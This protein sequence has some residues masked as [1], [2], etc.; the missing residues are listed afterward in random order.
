M[1]KKQTQREKPKDLG[2]MGSVAAGDRPSLWHAPGASFYPGARDTFEGDFGSLI[3]E[4]IAPGH[5]PAEPLLGEDDLVVTLG[6]CFARELRTFLLEAGL[7]S[8]R[9]RIPD[10]LNNTYA[11]LDF[12]TWCATGA[13]TGFGFSYDR[14]ASGEIAEFTPDAERESYAKAFADAGAFVFTLGLAEVWSDKATGGVFWRGIPEDVFEE[15]RHEFRLTTV[16]ENAR[17]LG[18]LI[19]QARSLNPSA[20]IVLTLS[21]VPLA[22]TFRGISCLTADCVSKSILRVAI[23]QVLSE[24]RPGVYYW[25]SFEIVRWAGSH[26]SWP[27][28]GFEDVRA[29]RVTRYVVGQIIDAFVEAYFTPGAAAKM[30]ERQAAGKMTMRSPASWSGKLHDIAARRER[31]QERARK[32]RARRAQ[33]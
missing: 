13:E 8:S 30:R 27:T 17:N 15:G 19:D 1:A 2:S 28:Y 3:R 21:P 12:F 6:S 10:A 9:F 24:E 7:E 20:P 4:H 32:W 31:K 25:P 22:A 16:D 33:S 11:L 29:R 5:S 23:D 26:L 14:A 18:G